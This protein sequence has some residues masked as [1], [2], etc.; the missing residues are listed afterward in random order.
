MTPPEETGQSDQLG[1]DTAGISLRQL[2][3]VRN[4]VMSEAVTRVIEESDGSGEV[5]A[6][7]QNRF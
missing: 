2:R 3:S 5:A 6:A 4:P 1:I 7:F